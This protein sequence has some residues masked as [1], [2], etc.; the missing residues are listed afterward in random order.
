MGNGKAIKMLYPRSYA[1]YAL[2]TIHI[3]IAWGGPLST[4]KLGFGE[5]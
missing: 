2:G 3:Y 1:A 4:K 5:D